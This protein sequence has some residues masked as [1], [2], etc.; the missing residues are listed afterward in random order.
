[1][2]QEYGVTGPMLADAPDA[3]DTPSVLAPATSEA[4][5][6]LLLDPALQN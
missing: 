5:A 6:A 3:A 1:M 2:A 4:P